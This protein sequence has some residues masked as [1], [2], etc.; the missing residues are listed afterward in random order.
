MNLVAHKYVTNLVIFALLSTV[1]RYL[2][3]TS[4]L[5]LDGTL[6][7]VLDSVAVWPAM[8]SYYTAFRNVARA[9]VSVNKEDILRG[10]ALKTRRDIADYC[11]LSV[12]ETT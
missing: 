1:V 3:K 9:C 7:R 2:S 12:P 10:M 8:V 11:R 4:F 6:S 5:A